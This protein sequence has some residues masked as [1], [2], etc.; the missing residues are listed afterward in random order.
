MKNIELFKQLASIRAQGIRVEE[1]WL[2]P[3]RYDELA[4]ELELQDLKLGR[5]PPEPRSITVNG[6][7]GSIRVRRDKEVCPCCGQEV[8]KE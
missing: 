3:K 7:G 4:E 5:V 1:I 6:M 2:E 8:K